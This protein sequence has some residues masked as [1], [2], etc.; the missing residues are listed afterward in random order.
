M[1]DNIVLIGFMGTGKTSIG[2]RLAR[3][4]NRQFVDTDAEIVKILGMPV[5]EIFKK[6]GEV[7]FR[8]EEKL[9]IQKLSAQKN[10]VISTGG[11]SI[12]H[13]E[14]LAIFQDNSM[15]VCLTASPEEII[16][17]VNRKKGTRPLLGK[18]VDVPLIE[19]MLEER[20]E[21][22]QQADHFISTDNRDFQLICQEIIDLLH[23]T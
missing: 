10:Q 23:T 9:L 19:A 6:L 12:Q 18:K 17:R 14:N 7:R 20:K 16:S 4:L 21:F 22:Y 5:K 15:I 1:K 13:S 2:I 11:G 3:T 8:S